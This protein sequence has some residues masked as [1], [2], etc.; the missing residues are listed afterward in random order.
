MIMPEIE[1][2]TR[3]SMSV[4]RDCLVVTVQ[5][6][7]HDEIMM[8]MQKDVLS[9]LSKSGVKGLIFDMSGV[10]IIDSYIADALL[11]TARMASLLSSYTV[12]VGMRSAVVSALVDLGVVLPAV[13]TALTL[14]QAVQKLESRN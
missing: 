11:D 8:Q 12:L 3:I 7:L 2:V 13:S 14:D 4:M 10:E 6:E 9:K 1:L 5:A